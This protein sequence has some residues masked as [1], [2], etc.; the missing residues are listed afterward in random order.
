MKQILF[1]SLTLLLFTSC[2]KEKVNAPVNPILGKW[3]YGLL[4]IHN[5]DPSYLPGYRDTTVIFPNEN[6]SYIDFRDDNVAY[7]TF[8]GGISGSSPYKIMG[9][10]ILI[11]NGDTAQ[12]ITITANKFT[13]YKKEVVGYAY[14]ETWVTYVK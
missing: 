3:E 6:G 2:R 11:L 14:S 12:I 5:Y 13:T 7:S 4:K 10:T 9:G 8:A 1:F